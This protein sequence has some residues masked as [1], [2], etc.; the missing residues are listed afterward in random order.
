M[1]IGRIIWWLAFIVFVLGC[2]GAVALTT[3]AYKV[4]E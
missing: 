4:E 3:W 2:A 1:N